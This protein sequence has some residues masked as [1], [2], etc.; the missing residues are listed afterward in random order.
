MPFLTQRLVVSARWVFVPHKK[1]LRLRIR[2][3]KMASLGDESKVVTAEIAAFHESLASASAATALFCPHCGS[4]LV[5]PS[6]S[7]IVCSSCQFRCNYA[8][9]CLLVELTWRD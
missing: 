6:S 7:T 1:P 3:L 5:L 9:A 4:L 2:S 8:G